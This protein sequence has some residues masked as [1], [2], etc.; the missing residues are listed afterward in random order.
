MIPITFAINSKD[1]SLIFGSKFRSKSINKWHA[2]WNV[3]FCTHSKRHNA[4]RCPKTPQRRPPG[5]PRRTQSA[6]K[7]A[8]RR[9]QDGPRH[10]QDGPN[11]AQLLPRPPRSPPSLDFGPSR[12]RF[13]TLHADLDFGPSIRRFSILH[14]LSC[15]L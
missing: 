15:I 2:R 12:P 5:S 4:L 10:P 6:P 14:I 1:F 7:T 13:W 11:C 9:L 3:S 8:P